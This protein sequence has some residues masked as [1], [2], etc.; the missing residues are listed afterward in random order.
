MAPDK[1]DATAERAR[2]LADANQYAQAIKVWRQLL[3]GSPN[4][5][6]VYNTIGDLSLKIK[7]NP[8][9][10]DAYHKAARLFVQEGFHLKAIAV[11]KKIR[12]LDPERAEVYT[13]LGDLNV[14]RGLMH[15]A[16][17]DY[18]SSAK[19]FLKTGKTMNALTLLRKIAKIDPQN[20]DVRMR[21]AELC[22]KEKL[23]DV[24]ITEFLYVGKAYQRQGRAAEA[25]TAF[26]KVLKLAP[27]HAEARRRLDSPYQPELDEPDPSA[28]EAAGM[29]VAD[30]VQGETVEGGIELSLPESTLSTPLQPAPEAEGAPATLPEARSL[31]ARGDLAKAERMVRALLLEDADQ[32][33]YQAILGLVYLKK[34]QIA[35]AYDTLSRIAQAWHAQGRCD[36]ASE[37]IDAYLMAEPDDSDFLQLK[38][39]VTQEPAAAT[40]E[41]PDLPVIPAG[42]EKP[43]VLEVEPATALAETVVPPATA[44]IPAGVLEPDVEALFQES[45]KGGKAPVGGDKYETHYD[46][47]VAYKEMGL[48][49]EAIEEF[50]LAARGPTRFVDACT[51]IAACYKAQR[52]NT[53]AVG[54]LERVLADPRCAGPGGPYVKYDLAVL[55]EEEG[56]TDK[57]ARLFADIPSVFDAQDRL[58]RLQGGLPP[59]GYSPAQTTRLFSNL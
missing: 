26:E 13:L 58:V 45:R 2:Q 34:G 54:L 4:D 55:Y 39:R 10:I 46:L 8:G 30:V 50:Q 32:L 5:A 43:A 44:G 16:V 27:D 22:L 6:N 3:D 25:R 57:A 47:G 28:T 20:T 41:T 49:T 9:A 53:T 23:K 17:A 1:K 37:L 36:E 19:L 24:A 59:A 31:L 33:E 52:L 56:L 29:T 18:L 11:Y 40:A 48:L 12:K 7:N 38:V 35:A 21:M 51:M 14:V 42:V 15:N